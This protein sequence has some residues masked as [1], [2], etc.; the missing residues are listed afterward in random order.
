MYMWKKINK[1]NKIYNY[2]KDSYEQFK[3]DLNRIRIVELDDKYNENDIDENIE[4]KFIF[5]MLRNSKL[6]KKSKEKI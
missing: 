3:N 6:L 4:K 1:Y 2:K 5:I